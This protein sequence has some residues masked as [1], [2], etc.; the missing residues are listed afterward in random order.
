[1]LLREHTLDLS[2]VGRGE[3]QGGAKAHRENGI[4]FV[5]AGLDPAI[6]AAGKLA[7]HVG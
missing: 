5:I 2:P 7:H 1:M 4:Y 3:E 6:H